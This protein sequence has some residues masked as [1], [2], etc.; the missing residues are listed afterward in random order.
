MFDAPIKGAKISFEEAVQQY[1]EAAYENWDQNV[2]E[3]CPNCG[4]T[5][6]PDSLKRHIKSCKPG[7][8][9][10]PLPKNSKSKFVASKN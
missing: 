5:F 2:L 3:Q 4:R 8:P 1:N 10:K 9:L 6:I 7:K